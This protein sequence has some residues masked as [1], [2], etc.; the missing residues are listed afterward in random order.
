LKRLVNLDAFP[1]RTL[2]PQEKRSGSG[3][4][5]GGTAAGGKIFAFASLLVC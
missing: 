5:P 3:L 1:R 2:A 4:V